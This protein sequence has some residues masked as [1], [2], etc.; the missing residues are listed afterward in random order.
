MKNFLREKHSK[1]HCGDMRIFLL[2]FFAGC[3]VVYFAPVGAMP[4]CLRMP[5]E[6]DE[7][8]TE[9]DR[10]Y[11]NKEEGACVNFMYGDCA[12]GGNSFASVQE[13]ESACRG[14]GRGP[15]QL[16]VPPKKPPHKGGKEPPKENGHLVEAAGHKNLGDHGENHLIL[17]RNGLPPRVPKKMIPPRKG[18]EGVN[19]NGRDHVRDRAHQSHLQNVQEVEAV[20]QDCGGKRV[21]LV[22]KA[23]GSI[24]VLS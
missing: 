15:P 24:M 2:P 1:Q 21:A 7:C 18:L 14:A 12:A 10:W 9:T 5:L 19:G 6:G 23:C 22:I 17:Q 11:F 3:N 8:E 4:D 16:P 20:V 13:C